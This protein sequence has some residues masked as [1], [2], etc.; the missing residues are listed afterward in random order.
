MIIGVIMLNIR[1]YL[2]EFKLYRIL[3]QNAHHLSRLLN[4]LFWIFMINNLKS[5]I[6]SVA[7]FLCFPSMS[8]SFILIDIPFII[9]MIRN[10]EPLQ[11]NK[12]KLYHYI[13]TITL[14]LPI[15]IAGIW[16]FFTNKIFF[17]EDVL[18]ID[19]ILGATLHFGLFLIFDPRIPFKTK[20]KE[21]KKHGWA[22]FIGNIL[23]LTFFILFHQL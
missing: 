7:I 16:S 12:M 1:L 4:L 20:D 5:N 19:I 8:I 9:R 22:L 15:I 17:M 18:L 6:L 14:H 11:S 21:E 10:K 2:T 23:T 3:K 13:E